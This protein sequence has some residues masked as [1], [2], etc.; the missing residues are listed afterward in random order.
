MADNSEENGVRQRKPER[1]EEK[2]RNV[3][4]AVFIAAVVFFA[5]AY[6]LF[7]GK[8]ADRPHIPG[9]NDTGANQSNGSAVLCNDDC[10]LTLVLNSGNS[11]YC[12]NMSSARSDECWQMFAHTDLNACLSMKAQAAR[13][14]CVG[15][16]AF[17]DK[18]A[19]ICDYL[20]AQDRQLCKEKINPPCMDIA[21]QPERELCL[22]LR[23][24][25]SSY[26]TSPQC[27]LS[28][29]Q[30][31]KDASV[32]GL[33]T[34]EAEQKACTSLVNGT[35]ICW[36]SSGSYVADYCYQLLAQYT[37]NYDYCDPITSSAY[38][39]SCTQSA[40][41]AERNVSYCKDNDLDYVWECYRN[42][43]MM[44]GDIEGCFAIDPYASGSRD[45]C[46][47][48]F[49]SQLG[50]PSACN[51]LSGVYAR[52][53]CYA[54]VILASQ[55]LTLDRCSAITNPSWGDK[56]FTSLAIKSNQKL[57][58]DYIDTGNP[59]EKERCESYFTGG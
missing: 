14:E 24:N 52:T 41:I 37:G 18:N 43:S 6:F 45:G 34:S 54:N 17:A 56:C 28:Y 3:I 29:A 32:C 9:Q 19:S 40:A 25:K 16:L 48:A 1:P 42:Y 47:N 21:A 15:D 8:G 22:A 36:A 57:A 58:C 27:T 11:S 44:T 59:D 10:I 5:L 51:Y 53:N 39:F 26:C 7:I 31:R 2:L 38:R 23:N 12:R 35:D 20:D 49:A 46:L 30:A 13:K 50:D 55:N 4:I 33:L